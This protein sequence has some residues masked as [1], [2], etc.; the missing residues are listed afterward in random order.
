MFIISLSW[1]Y[2]QRT[3]LLN[4]TCCCDALGPEQHPE[5]CLLAGCLRGCSS[6]AT[7]LTCRICKDK[8]YGTVYRGGEVTRM[9]LSNFVAR[10]NGEPGPCLAPE[11]ISCFFFFLIHIPSICCCLWESQSR[12]NIYG[13]SWPINMFLGVTWLTVFIRLCTRNGERTPTKLCCGL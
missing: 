13:I 11:M 3:P 1:L 4:S 12:K 9:D 2:I 6:G 5:V 10:A 7:D 8:V